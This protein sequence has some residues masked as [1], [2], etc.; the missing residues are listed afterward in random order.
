MRKS[1]FITLAMAL[2]ITLT[3]G[4]GGGGGGGGDDVEWTK[5]AWAGD[6]VFPLMVYSADGQQLGYLMERNMN[7]QGVTIYNEEL[8]LT[9]RLV[10]LGDKGRFSHPGT[11][12]FYRDK[13][14]EGLYLMEGYANV[15]YGFYYKV[16]EDRV[17]SYPE[18]QELWVVSS[19]ESVSYNTMGYSG[20]AEAFA[21]A[22][23]LDTDGSI[24]EPGWDWGCD[25]PNQDDLSITQYNYDWWVDHY[26]GSK[27]HK[28][29]PLA[30]ANLPFTY[31]IQLPISISSK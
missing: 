6:G 11:T 29:V 22:D 28:L 23:Y 15:V 1:I 8:G 25:D 4:C 21:R 2:F 14:C 17:M 5:P 31:P 10:L 13:N 24:Y 26:P 7:A 3:F 18:D 12:V 9:F 20:T 30:L 27:A 16:H 19:T